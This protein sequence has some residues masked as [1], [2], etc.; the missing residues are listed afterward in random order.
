VWVAVWVGI[1]SFNFLQRKMPVFSRKQAFL[2]LLTRFEL[3]TSSL[4]KAQ[5][6]HF[7]VIHGKNIK[8]LTYNPTFCGR[9]FCFEPIIY[10]LIT[11]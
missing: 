9:I 5:K 6:E 3:V 1:F 2:E 8:N 7:R 4:P 10:D 11:G